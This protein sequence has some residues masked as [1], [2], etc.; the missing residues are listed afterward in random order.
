M[1]YPEINQTRPQHI[2]L[3]YQEG[4]KKVINKLKLVRRKGIFFRGMPDH[5][6]AKQFS[7][8]IS[9]SL[10]SSK[11]VA[12]FIFI[13]FIQNSLMVTPENVNVKCKTR[14]KT[15]INLKF[16]LECILFYNLLAMVFHFYKKLQHKYKY[17]ADLIG[18]QHL[19][20]KMTLYVVTKYC[21]LS[22]L[23]SSVGQNNLALNPTEKNISSGGNA[24]H[25][26]MTSYYLSYS[27]GI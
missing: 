21:A 8:I 14:L 25:F 23:P 27:L 11:S 2:F 13:S 7:N 6:E 5:E 19:I 17:K 20:G 15:L 4:E 10:I 18:K 24:P 22:L 12:A 9:L 26:C 1:L 3:L 16:K